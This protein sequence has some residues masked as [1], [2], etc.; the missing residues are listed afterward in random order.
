MMWIAPD[1]ATFGLPS[2]IQFISQFHFGDG[3]NYSTFSHR[4][5]T[6]SVRYVRVSLYSICSVAPC[7]AVAGDYQSPTLAMCCC[8]NFIYTIL[9]IGCCLK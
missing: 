7:V 1:I 9:I 4:Y 6:M 2:L 8:K 5:T 3:K